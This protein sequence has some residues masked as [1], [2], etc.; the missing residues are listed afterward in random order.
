MMVID[1]TNEVVKAVVDFRSVVSMAAVE[2]TKKM[3]TSL[4]AVVDLSDDGATKEAVVNVRSA[5]SMAAVEITRGRVI[6]LVAIIDLLLLVWLD[7]QF[8]AWLLYFAAY[9]P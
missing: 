2:V 5:I 8:R 9:L 3:V 6:S 1:L 4:V 7:L